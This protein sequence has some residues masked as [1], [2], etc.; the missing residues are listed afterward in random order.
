MKTQIK[1]VVLNEHTLGY[2]WP[3]ELDLP[4]FY[5]VGILSASILKGANKVEGSVPFTE[6]VDKIRLASKKDFDNFRHSFEG[7]AND[8]VYEYIYAK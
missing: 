8:K 4:G 3:S 1:L 5:S 7:Y 6:G 2:V